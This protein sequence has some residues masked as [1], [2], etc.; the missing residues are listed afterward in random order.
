VARDWK[1]VGDE[2]LKVVV[3][4]LQT[5]ILIDPIAPVHHTRENACVTRCILPEIILHQPNFECVI[6]AIRHQYFC[7]A[8]YN[9]EKKHHARGEALVVVQFVVETASC[10]STQQK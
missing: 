1:I 9:E 6:A 5:T 4:I 3:V 7:Q 8:H 2:K 10:S